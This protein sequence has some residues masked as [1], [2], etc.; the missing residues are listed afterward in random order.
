MAIIF[1]YPR[2]ANDIEAYGGVD[3]V[4]TTIIFEDEAG[5]TPL[6]ISGYTFTAKF[7]RNVGSTVLGS[8]A[9]V[10]NNGVTTGQVIVTLQDSSLPDVD[11][12]T[13]GRW[14]LEGLDPSG[15]LRI[16]DYGAFNVKD[17]AS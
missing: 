2:E 13:I 8:T 1:T 4:Y 7:F 15:I 11:M 9:V 6:N 10:N 17:N 3:M 5:T 12:D 14:E 16:Y